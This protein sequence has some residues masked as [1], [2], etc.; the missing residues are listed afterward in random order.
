MLKIR[1]KSCGK[2]RNR[3]SFFAF[4]REG[5][6][7]LGTVVYC[8][9]V[10]VTAASERT[11]SVLTLRKR[12]V[13]RRRVLRSVSAAS[14]KTAHPLPPSSFPVRRSSLRPGDAGVLHSA[15][16]L[17]LIPSLSASHRWNSTAPRIAAVRRSE[18]GLPFP[19]HGTESDTFLDN[20]AH[21]TS[22]PGLSC[23]GLLRPGL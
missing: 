13:V 16:A 19:R 8:R 11:R 12:T 2:L 22:G 23:K 17:L 10:T 15:A 6:V 18:F 9:C 3:F 1:W 4:F 14:A 21:S 20:P 7:V 5:L